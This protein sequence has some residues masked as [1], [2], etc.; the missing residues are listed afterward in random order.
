MPEPELVILESKGGDGVGSAEVE[1]KKGRPKG[2]EDV[3]LKLI[4]VGVGVVVLPTGDVADREAGGPV[5]EQVG[6]PEKEDEQLS[7]VPLSHGSSQD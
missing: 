3:G 7:G 4:G 2:L 6:R 5:G 1:E